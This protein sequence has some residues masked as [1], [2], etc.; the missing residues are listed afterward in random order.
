MPLIR[1]FWRVP[2]EMF[3]SLRTSLDLSHFFCCW[4][5]IANRVLRS[6]INN[7]RNSFK[8]SFVII[9]TDITGG[10]NCY[11]AKL[12]CLIWFVS[13]RRR[14]WGRFFVVGFLLSVF[15]Y[16]LLVFG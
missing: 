3:N 2:G 8:S 1:R 7:R 10:F 5:L 9:S 14:C 15:C 6:A 12:W 4:G 13:Q 16:L 11:G